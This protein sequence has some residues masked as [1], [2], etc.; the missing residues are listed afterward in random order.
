MLVTI[1]WGRRVGIIMA[2]WTQRPSDTVETMRPR[3]T[4]LNKPD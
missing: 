1:F 3:P 4:A 2:A